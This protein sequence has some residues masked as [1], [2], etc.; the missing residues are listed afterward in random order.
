METLGSEREARAAFLAS[1]ARS[2]GALA[3]I[4]ESIADVSD[5]SQGTVKLLRDNVRSLTE[6]QETIAESVTSLA[7]HRRVKRKGNPTKPWLQP[8]LPIYGV[9]WSGGEGIVEQ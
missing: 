1:L 7:W 3:R 8:E 5:A 4:L 9:Y 2:Q 6:L